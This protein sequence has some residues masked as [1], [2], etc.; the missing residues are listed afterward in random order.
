MSAAAEPVSAAVAAAKPE[1]KPSGWQH[2]RPLLSYCAK[3]KGK[4][5]VGLFAL[6]L[7]GILGAVPQLLQG[8]IADSLTGL[9]R[10]LATLTGTS[11]ALLRPLLSHYAPLSVHALG[12]FCVAIIVFVGTKGFFT[13]WSRWILIGISR[14]IEFDL[15]N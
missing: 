4:T 14:E 7:T 3:Y 11:R 8:I 1:R 9:P 13:F 12:F 5:F 6:A 2:M 10:P 15:R